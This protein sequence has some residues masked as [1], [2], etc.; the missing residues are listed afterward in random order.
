MEVVDKIGDDRRDH[1]GVYFNPA[2]SGTGPS[3]VSSSTTHTS[4][5]KRIRSSYST[6]D[7]ALTPVP[8]PAFA[9]SSPSSSSSVSQTSNVSVI[10]SSQANHRLFCI[11]C[12]HI[13]LAR[14]SL[15]RTRLTFQSHRPAAF[16]PLSHFPLYP[17]LLLL[18]PLHRTS[19]ATKQSFEFPRRFIVM[20]SR[21]ETPVES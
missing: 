17:V 10:M 20:R 11:S 3:P 16:F 6:L 5:S 15:T 19:V 21:H 2:V 12:Q 13:I 4:A 7:F 14:P 9:P 18:R 8:H 1:D